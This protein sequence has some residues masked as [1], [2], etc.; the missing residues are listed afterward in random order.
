VRRCG[1]RGE[2]GEARRHHQTPQVRRC[3]QTSC[4]GGWRARRGMDGPPRSRTGGRVPRQ[5]GF[6]ARLRKIIFAARRR[7]ARWQVSAPSR[8]AVD[9]K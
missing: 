3:V 7:A 9:C 8:R 1:D 5:R 6:V 2:S 4:N